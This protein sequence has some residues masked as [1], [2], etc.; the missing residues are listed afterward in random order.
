MTLRVL[1]VGAGTSFSTKDVEQGL[2]KGLRSHG[3][4]CYVYS[5]ERRLDLAVEW[6]RWLWTDRGK[7]PEDKPSWADALYRAGV[8]ALEMALRFQVDWVIVISAMFL[9]PDVLVLLRRAG[10]HVGIVFTESPYQDVEQANVASA[11][12]VCWTNERSSVAYLRH[13]NPRTS[14]LPAAYDPDIHTPLAE[15]DLAVPT[16]D[17]VF[18]GTGWQ[19][20][21]DLLRAVDWSG[22]DLGLYGAWSLLGSRSKL[23]EFVRSGFIDNRQTAA[24]YRQATIGLNL[25]RQ[26]R[27]FGPKPSYIEH[28][29]SLNPRAYELAACGVFH[30]SDQRVEGQE[31]F[32]DA[33]PTF[34]DADQLGALIREY[35]ADPEGRAVH[36]QRARQAIRPH[37]YAARA[38]QL[39]A[40]LEHLEARPFARGA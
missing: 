21:C 20:R 30:L 16:H 6:L 26:S 37:T 14:Y 28:A 12:D 7:L 33:V 38:A 10:V 22:I 3:A 13:A 29:E 36:A 31:I 34:T 17:V 19:E 32:G 9:H 27:A 39:V 8:E 2:L 35:L 1:I 23:R 11:V 5:L 18:V 25:Y 4:E 40:D 15:A 24:L